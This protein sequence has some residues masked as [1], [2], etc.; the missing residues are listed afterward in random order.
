MAGMFVALRKTSKWPASILGVYE[1]F[2]TQLLQLSLSLLTIKSNCTFNLIGYRTLPLIFL[3]LIF[4]LHRLT[5]AMSTVLIMMNITLIYVCTH[6]N[7]NLL[8][9]VNNTKGWT[10]WST[11]KQTKCQCSRERDEKLLPQ[12]VNNK[13][14]IPSLYFEPVNASSKHYCIPIVPHTSS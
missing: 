4:T 9:I 10:L 7:N 2:Q 13:K 12:Y 5:K 1:V 14:K 11:N 6:N 8:F 3:N